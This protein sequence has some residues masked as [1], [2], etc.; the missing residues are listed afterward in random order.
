MAFDFQSPITFKKRRNLAGDDIVEIT[1]AGKDDADNN[2]YGGNKARVL[3]ALD[4]RGSTS[5]RELAHDVSL[6][7]DTVK[8]EVIGLISK[9]KVALKG[10]G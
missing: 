10:G 8:N 1:G 3:M 2:A 7:L 4:E 5:I 6:P 9:G